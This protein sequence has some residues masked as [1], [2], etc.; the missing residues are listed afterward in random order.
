V[1]AF[2]PVDVQPVLVV[3]QWVSWNVPLVGFTPVV[4]TEFWST[5]PPPLDCVEVVLFFT[6]PGAFA[7]FPGDAGGEPWPFPFPA[8]AEPANTAIPTRSTN[9]LMRL[10]ERLVIFGPLL[11]HKR[12]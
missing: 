8:K 3:L 4:E 2:T 6:C 12:S 5:L 11:E 10:A 1:V 7:E 9:V